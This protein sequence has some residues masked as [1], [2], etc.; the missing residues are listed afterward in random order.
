L[1]KKQ[2]LGIVQTQNCKCNETC[3]KAVTEWQ[4][5]CS[6]CVFEE[7]GYLVLLLR[8]NDD[9]EMRTSLFQ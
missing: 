4:M 6:L 8:L 2:N 3:A 7:S 9:S 1:R 5:T